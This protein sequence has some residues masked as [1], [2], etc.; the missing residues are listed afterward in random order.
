MTTPRVKRGN[1]YKIAFKCN[2][3]TAKRHLY[4]S[5]QAETLDE[6]M[7]EFMDVLDKGNFKKGYTLELLT[8]NWKLLTYQ[9][10]KGGNTNES[11]NICTEEGN[12]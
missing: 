6:A 8:G 9:I 5:F 1:V 2:R 10:I 12:S 7:L 3:K 4:K 11:H